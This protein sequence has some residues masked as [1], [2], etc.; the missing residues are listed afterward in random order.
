M[1]SAPSKW[2]RTVTGPEMA[3]GVWTENSLG[4]FFP[5]VGGEYKLEPQHQC[6]VQSPNWAL[7]RGSGHHED[8][9][10]KAELKDYGADTQLS[11]PASGG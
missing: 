2:V 10:G 4:C 7:P 11:T 1:G 3:I 9:L 6:A 8:P 5:W